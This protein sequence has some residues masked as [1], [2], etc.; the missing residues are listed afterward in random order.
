MSSN[1]SAQPS[2]VFQP[3]NKYKFSKGETI[4]VFSGS[5]NG[6]AEVIEEVGDKITLRINGQDVTCDKKSL[7]LEK[8]N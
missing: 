4:S 6:L 3:Y 7:V 8:T 1:N 5:L 2:F